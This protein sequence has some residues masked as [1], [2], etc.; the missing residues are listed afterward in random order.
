VWHMVRVAHD[1]RE[2]LIGA[3]HGPWE[4]LIGAVHGPWEV[5]VGAAHGVRKRMVRCMVDEVRCVTVGE[6]ECGA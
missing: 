2:V 6:W 3:V 1:V 4:V 5:H